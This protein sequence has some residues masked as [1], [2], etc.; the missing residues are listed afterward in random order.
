M[1]GVYIDTLV[2]CTL[3]GII[4][5]Q[6]LLHYNLD[7]SNFTGPDVIIYLFEFYFDY[8]GKILG[9]L[10]ILLFAFSSI[11]GE[12]Y[13]GETNL[14]YLN[15][16]RKTKIIYRILFSI[17]LFFGVF[18]T[19]EQAMSLIDFGI[20]LIGSINIFIVINLLKKEN[21]VIE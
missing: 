3:T 5:V 19:T 15:H 1:L 8:F 2:L 14:L 10:F 12:F 17:T 7:L 13:L 20:I 16:S 9:Y 21:Y 4:V 6:T 18:Y 11:I